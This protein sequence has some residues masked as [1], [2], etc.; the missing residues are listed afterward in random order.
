MPLPSQEKLSPE[1]I[2]D[3]KELFDAVAGSTDKITLSDFKKALTIGGFKLDDKLVKELFDKADSD[4]SGG[5][6]WPEF[7]K[8][9]EARPIKKRIEAKLRQVFDNIDKDKSGQLDKSDVKALLKEVGASDKLTDADI[10]HI[11]KTVDKSG[12]GKV[13]FEEFATFAIDN[14]F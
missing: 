6:T 2:K 4:K 9:V 10:D 5:V 8:V 11:I 3:A 12:D 7:L 1:E 13:S 14:F